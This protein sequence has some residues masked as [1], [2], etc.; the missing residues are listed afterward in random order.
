MVQ[1]IWKHSGTNFA[2]TI[3]SFSFDG[4]AH[5]L[6]IQDKNNIVGISIPSSFDDKPC[7]VFRMQMD[8]H[9][10][11]SVGLYKGCTLFNDMRNVRFGYGWQGD[12]GANFVRG[13]DDRRSLT[14]KIFFDEET[15]CCISEE[16]LRIR[17]VDFLSRE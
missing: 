4:A 1:P 16:D 10:H 14:P 6:V 12:A 9:R 2:S 13:K 15:G 3:P 11:R 7:V 5:R 17:V 8:L